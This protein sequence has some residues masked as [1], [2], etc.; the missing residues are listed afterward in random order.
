MLN[1]NLYFINRFPHSRLESLLHHP[2]TIHLTHRRL[3]PP[4]TGTLQ[5][6]PGSAGFVRADPSRVAWGPAL[7]GTEPTRGRAGLL[8]RFPRPQTLPLVAETLA[9]VLAREQLVARMPARDVRDVAW[10]VFTHLWWSC[11]ICI[12]CT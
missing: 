6:Y 3:A 12:M 2:R 9:L 1:G 7:V 11:D 5:Q 8:A 10:Y 4:T